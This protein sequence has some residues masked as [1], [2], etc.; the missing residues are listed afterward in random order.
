V[1]T[2]TAPI[3]LVAAVLGA[4]VFAIF[5]SDPA[6]TADPTSTAAPAHEAPGRVSPGLAAPGMGGAAGPVDPNAKLPPNHPALDAPPSQP[7][8]VAP[9]PDD[10]PNVVWKAPAA[11][12]V[13]PNPSTM[14][15][16]TY[17]VAGTG[18]EAE[19]SVA[20]AGGSADANI[21]RWLGQ[22]DDAGKDTRTEKTV[23]G[24]KVTIVEVSGTYLGGM[25]GAP[26][27]HPGWSLLAAI[28]EGKGDPY[29]FKMTGPTATVR[30]ARPAF[31]GMVDGLTP[32]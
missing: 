29:F 18:G 5:R 17:K 1:S 16:A 19:L 6:P 21:E 13:A 23:K 9:N 7:A 26:G 11:W 14:R 2:R 10:S 4:G 31:D 22:F 3:A 20:R 28:V 27:S 32:K 8:T 30:A 15:L 25:T 12:A 24:M